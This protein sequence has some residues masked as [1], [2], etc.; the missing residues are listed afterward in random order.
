MPRDRRGGRPE[1][2]SAAE[3][4]GGHPL[5]GLER[6]LRA[7]PRRRLELLEEVGADA[8][9]L[10][11]ELMRRGSRPILARD[12]AL[13]RLVPDRDALRDL[14][15]QHASPLQRWIQSMGRAER[16]ERLGIG[17]AALVAGAAAWLVVR[18]PGSL[19]AASP[20]AWVQIVVF[21]LLAANWIQ[22]AFG[23]WVDGDVRP[24]RRRT[25]W[26]RQ[27]GLMVFAVALGAFGTAWEAYAA[28]DA[29]E[30]DAATA[31]TAWATAR[32]AVF[33]AALGVGAA[34]FG[35]FGWVSLLPRL[36][37]DEAIERRISAFFRRSGPRP[38]LVS[39]THERRD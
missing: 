21:A 14:E 25:L 4:P 27:V 20:L 16:I 2:G 7:P 8:E 23:L 9:A 24:Y 18:A 39:T 17:A 28:M 11:G 30:A 38:G 36:I 19:G 33:F 12:A 1:A 6:N 31:L 32:R 15:A 34:T 26:R 13:R 5:K 3:P 35:L 37:T 29:L 10:E 22:A